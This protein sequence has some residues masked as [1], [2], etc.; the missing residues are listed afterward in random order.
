[1]VEQ[2]VGRWVL[3]AFMLLFAA[4]SSYIARLLFRY[5]NLTLAAQ[6]WF[7]SIENDFINKDKI[8]KL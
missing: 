5:A 4:V 3:F 8:V 6:K 1:M 7:L 2:F